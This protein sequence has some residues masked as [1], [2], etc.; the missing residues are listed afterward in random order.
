[1]TTPQQT[2]D[3]SKGKQTGSAAAGETKATA[4]RG[5]E[6]AGTT[7]AE[8][9]IPTHG[10]GT[11]AQRGESAARQRA[12]T[13]RAGVPALFR[14]GFPATPWELVR[15]M[16]EQMD[17]LF[18]GL[19]TARPGGAMLAQPATA[20]PTGLRSAADLGMPLAGEFM[21]QIEVLQ[22]PGAFVVRADLPGIAPDEIDVTVEEGMLTISGERREER[23]EEDEGFVRSEVSYGT[24]VRTIPLPEGADESRVAATFRNGVLEITVPVS[25]QRQRGRRVKVQS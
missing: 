22:R 25:E 20:A 15:R 13:A 10:E 19:G 9:P 7:E 6:S 12:G 8:R 5:T 17:Q 2:P 4:G 24:F 16:S 3:E 23:R 21:P 18:G 1:M 11:A 14:P